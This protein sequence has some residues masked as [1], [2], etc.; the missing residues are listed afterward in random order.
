MKKHLAGVVS[1]LLIFLGVGSAFAASLPGLKSITGYTGTMVTTSTEVADPV[2]DLFLQLMTRPGVTADSDITA[3]RPTARN[4]GMSFQFSLLRGGTGSAKF[5]TFRD[6]I[7][8]L[9]QTYQAEYNL[10]PPGEA[11]AEARGAA[12]NRLLDDLVSTAIQDGISGDELVNAML[13][14]ATTVENRLSAFPLSKVLSLPDKELVKL[15]LQI[16]IDQ[17]R[18]RAFT[19]ATGA[20]LGVVNAAAEFTTAYEN[21]I[22]TLLGTVLASELVSW[23]RFLADPLNVADQQKL[24]TARYN[25]EANCDLFAMKYGMETMFLYFQLQETQLPLIAGRIPAMTPEILQEQ[26]GLAGGAGFTALAA[27]ASIPSDMSLLYTP[28]NGL[29]DQLAALGETVP[30]PPDFYLFSDPYR[31]LARMNYDILL[32]ERIL[33]K[34]WQL[35]Q[36]NASSLSRPLKFAEQLT[37]KTS[38]IR[39]ISSVRSHVTGVPADTAKALIRLLQAGFNMRI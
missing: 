8:V 36:D 13:S 1:F 19:A 7:G 37:L 21:R 20:A 28:V 5:A 33:N 22:Y 27:Y 17:V 34:E 2:T 31:S 10:A 14:G 3:L 38:A 18:R 12:L 24:L 29:A 16:G 26:L 35:A 11:G 30:P 32:C 4:G 25:N 39:R 6:G 15:L 23:E 9:V